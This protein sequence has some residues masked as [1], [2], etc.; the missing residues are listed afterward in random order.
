MQTILT[1]DFRMGQ[2]VWSNVQIPPIEYIDW[3]GLTRG[4]E[5]SQYPQEKKTTVILL[6]AASEKGTA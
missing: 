1:G 3:K 6:V 2:P 5:T 4:S